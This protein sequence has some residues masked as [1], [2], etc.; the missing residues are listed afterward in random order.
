MGDRRVA[1]TVL[2]GR[3][4]GKRNSEDLGVDGRIILKLGFK[5]WEWAWPGLFC[6]RLGTGGGHL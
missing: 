5:K 4:N 6:L 1:F 3:F 2:V